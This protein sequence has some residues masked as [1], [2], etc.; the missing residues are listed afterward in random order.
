MRD[1]QLSSWRGVLT[2]WALLVLLAA[3]VGPAGS[4]IAAAAPSAADEPFRIWLP[5]LSLNWSAAYAGMVLV[6]GGPFQMGC[7]EDNPG[8]AC[9]ANELPLHAVTLD[10]YY[11]DQ[12]EVTNAQYGLCV[13]AAACDP[14]PYSHSQTRSAYY[15]NPDYDDYPVIWVNWNDARDYC[16]W[17]GKRLP[18][19][20]EWE[21]AAR[22]SG[23][24]RIYPWGD[25]DPDCSRLNYA[26]DQYPGCVGDTSRV[27]AYPTGASPYGALDMAGNVF[28]WVNDWYQED[29]YSVSPAENPQGPASGLYRLW[30]GG[31]WR[32]DWRDVRTA[33]R[34]YDEPDSATRYGWIGFRCALTPGQ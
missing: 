21:K 34:E 15:G 12:H 32:N 8:E 5:A 26:G 23:D 25:E 11:I 16:A 29:Y 7:D 9:Y 19:E 22:G 31:S 20:A 2:I 33:F 27:G 1:R 28:E 30:R 24:A 6:P 4:G 3:V 14:P 18:T 13:A 10:S 17:A